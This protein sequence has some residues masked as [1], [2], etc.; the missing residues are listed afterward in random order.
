MEMTEDGIVML[1][2]QTNIVGR[3]LR[4]PYGTAE[5]REDGSLAIRLDDDENAPFWLQV[6]LTPEQVKVLFARLKQ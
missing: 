3:G 6:T 5:L 2:K 1:K 4:E